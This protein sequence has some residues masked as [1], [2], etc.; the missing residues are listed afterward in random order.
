MQYTGSD[1]GADPSFKKDGPK[2]L[3][4]TW[5]HGQF[6]CDMGLSDMRQGLRIIVTWDIA[7]SQNR[8]A[9]LGVS[10][11]GPQKGASINSRHRYELEKTMMRRMC[12]KERVRGV[13]I[14]PLSG[15]KTRGPL[16][17]SH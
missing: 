6:E 4:S 15:E 9:T 8:H 11:K 2:P 17:L 1:C 7:F 5:R 16:I 13:I 14:G 12:T 10:H 3:K